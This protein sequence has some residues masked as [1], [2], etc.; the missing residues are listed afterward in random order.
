L[1][2]PRDTFDVNVLGTVNVLDAARRASGVRAVICVTSDKCYENRPGAPPFREGDPLGGRDPYSASKACAE[3][4]VACYRES[5][6]APEQVAKHGVG[7]A[8]VRAG[9]VIGGG[10]WAADRIVPDCIRALTADLTITIRSPAAVRPWQ[11]VLE[12]LAG[13]LILA[14]RLCEEPEKYAGEWNFGPA[15]GSFRPVADLVEQVIRCWGSG[16]WQTEAYRSL[17]T[18]MEADCL[19]LSSDKA[20]THLPWRP[21]WSFGTAIEHTVAWYRAFY[22][23]VGAAELRSLG[24]RQIADYEA[25]W[26]RS[27]ATAAQGDGVPMGVT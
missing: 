20:M 7:V 19:R 13:Y 1:Q 26:S 12:P 6:F 14:R 22:R 2:L 10:D 4:V 23:Q 21:Q 8:S 9:N 15:G 27:M 17:A 25:R 3:L 5:Y 24:S 18:G 11:H 16:R